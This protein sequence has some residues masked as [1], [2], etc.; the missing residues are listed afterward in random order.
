MRLVEFKHVLVEG[1]NIWN[2]DL[3]TV[4]I[5]RDKVRPTVIFLEKVTG[6]QLINNMLGS[7]GVKETSGDID[8]AV[9]P[10]V[11][12]KDAL[13]AELQ[14]WA[15]KHDPSALV[16]K[17]G[18]S[19]HFR[20][21]IAGNPK[22]GYVQTDFMMIENVDLVKWSMKSALN[23][24]YRDVSKQ[25]V[26]SSLGKALGF[27]WSP[28]KG[29]LNRETNKIVTTNPDKIAKLLLN[30]KAT[31]KNLE[32]VENILSALASDPKAEEKLQDARETLAKEGITLSLP[33]KY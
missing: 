31:G 29:L 14:A 5:P 24:S 10:K 20:T 33:N 3:A 2:G 23:S 22:L 1:G 4:R 7:T 26:I 11:I 8:L 6:L 30:K 15:K 12:S 13:F 32:S 21:P 25:I 28:T 19:V 27:R 9:D 16:K 17:T 18:I